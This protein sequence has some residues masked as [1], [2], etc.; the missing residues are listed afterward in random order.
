MWELDE[1]YTQILQRSIEKIQG[2]RDK[3]RLSQAFKQVL[4]SFAILAEPLP[5][6][7]L[8][9]LFQ[10][11][12]ET[13]S[14]RVRHLYSVLN[15]PQNP[16]QP[17]QLLHPSFCDFLLDKQRCHDQSFWVGESQAHQK[18]SNNCIRLMSETLKK[19][20]CEM[21]AP[22]SLATSVESTRIQ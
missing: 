14:L 3:D 21:N 4:G 8:A 13:V 19:D 12:L 15:I 18:L 9:N 20:I 11:R 6:A 2:G 17:I 5:S 1:I 16:D 22:G 7:T 10:I